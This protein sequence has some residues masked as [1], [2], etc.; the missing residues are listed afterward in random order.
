MQILPKVYKNTQTAADCP[1]RLRFQCK[2]AEEEIARLITLPLSFRSRYSAACRSTWMLHEF[3]SISDK[4]C[5]FESAK[6][7]TDLLI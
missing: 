6:S 7:D 4:Q 5:C 2:Q 3:T 1:K